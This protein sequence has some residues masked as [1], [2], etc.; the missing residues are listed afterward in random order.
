[1]EVVFLFKGYFRITYIRIILDLNLYHMPGR[2]VCQFP[3]A[4]IS[5]SLIKIRTTFGKYGDKFNE[6]ITYMISI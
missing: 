5:G 6:T 1:M 3:I 4:K 2:I